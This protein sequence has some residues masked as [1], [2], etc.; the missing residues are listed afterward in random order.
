MDDR[1]GTMLER[2][3]KISEGQVGPRPDHSCVNHVNTLREIIQGRKDA[4]VPTYCSD[5]DV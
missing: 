2:E 5:L 4:V 1:V 3:Q